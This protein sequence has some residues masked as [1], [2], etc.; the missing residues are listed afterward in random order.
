MAVDLNGDADYI[1]CGDL[2]LD[3][4][5]AWSVSAWVKPDDPGGVNIALAVDFITNAGSDADHVGVGVQS[6]TIDDWKIAT[7]G[8]TPN[9]GSDVSYGTLYHLVLV[10]D[11]TKLILYVNANEDYNVTPTGSN[12]QGADTFLIGGHE[13]DDANMY[14]NG[15]INEVA[16]W[17][18]Q[19]STGEISQLYKGKVKRMPLQIQPSSLVGYWPL[20]DYADGTALNTDADGYKDLSGNG[21]HGQ[22]VDA[23][24]DSLN[25][26]ETV[27]SYP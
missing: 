22:G 19:L 8:E 14:W 20:D 5:S 7:N 13:P 17:S 15:G 9:D 25:V 16:V 1:N 4:S 6:S 10:Y 2:S 23:D 11:G 21:N 27:L 24:N 3:L 26:A 12:W 18:T